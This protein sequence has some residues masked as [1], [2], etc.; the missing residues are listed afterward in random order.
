MHIVAN[1][2]DSKLSK[3]TV[4]SYQE[5]NSMLMTKYVPFLINWGRE[6]KQKS[7]QRELLMSGQDA[8]MDDSE[9]QAA[10][11]E[12]EFPP[13]HYMIVKETG[14]DDAGLQVE[15]NGLV[16]TA[17]RIACKYVESKPTSSSNDGVDVS[18]LKKYSANSVAD[19]AEVND[20]SS[21]AANAGYDN[22]QGGSAAAATGSSKTYK[23][24][25]FISDLTIDMDDPAV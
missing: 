16:L 11:M 25:E 3:E 6:M 9:N 7:K 22:E 23:E 1:K 21:T 8:Q 4:E 17:S 24:P 12:E 19:N 13:I 5:L 15:S 2:G 18:F 14:S 20:A 10:A